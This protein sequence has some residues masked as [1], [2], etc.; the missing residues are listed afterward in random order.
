MQ[1]HRYYNIGLL[2]SRFSFQVVPYARVPPFA[3]DD[4][5]LV[6]SM[7][8]QMASNCIFLKGERLDGQENTKGLS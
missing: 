3:I 2:V 8:L 4:G 7:P 1:G 5:V 6:V